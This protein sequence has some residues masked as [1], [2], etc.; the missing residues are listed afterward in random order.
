M[1]ALTHAISTTALFLSAAICLATEFL[2]NRIARVE[3]R[4]G[5]SI[6]H[7]EHH[8]NYLDGDAVEVV[9][10]AARVLA[11]AGFILLFCS[12]TPAPACVGAGLLVSGVLVAATYVNIFQSSGGGAD[13][14]VVFAAFG[15]FFLLFTLYRMFLN[16]PEEG[17]KGL[18]R[19]NSEVP[20]QGGGKESRVESR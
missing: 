12:G 11:V 20:P 4:M 15:F 8:R 6:A 14:W 3:E 2:G 19:S 18:G 17:P 5:S 7:V 16:D 10:W 13:F 9:V 1:R